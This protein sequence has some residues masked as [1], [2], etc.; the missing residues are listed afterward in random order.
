MVGRLAG[1]ALWTFLGVVVLTVAAVALTDPYRAARLAVI[2]FFI[3]PAVVGLT[4]VISRATRGAPRI[5]EIGRSGT[6]PMNGSFR[7]AIRAQSETITR[8]AWLTGAGIGLLLVLLG[9]VAS[10]GDGDPLALEVF[11]G[12]G[13]FVF[14]VTVGAA[15][16]SGR[17]AGRDLA[18]NAVLTATGPV[19]VS[20]AGGV[21]RL[22]VAGQSFWVRESVARAVGNR[23]WVKVLYTPYA[24]QVLDV[25]DAQNQ[26]IYRDPRFADPDAAGVADAET[27]V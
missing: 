3:I 7:A 15:W 1:W 18:A 25:R 27:G 22:Y 12:I 4:R 11:G 26:I 6:L 20:G 10:L 13:V 23:D 17:A 21:Y 19:E 9:A 5:R 24:H 14:V 2:L 8:R 16:F